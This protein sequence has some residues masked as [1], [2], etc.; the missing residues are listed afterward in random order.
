[1]PVYNFNPWSG[2]DHNGK[3]YLG[4]PG[5]CGVFLGTEAEDPKYSGPCGPEYSSYRDCLIRK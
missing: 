5:L 3:K 4:Q 2:A 1:M